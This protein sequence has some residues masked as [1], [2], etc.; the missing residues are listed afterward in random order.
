MEPDK[1]QE[2]QFEYPYHYIPDW[3]QDRFSQTHHFAWGF[4]Y[5][6][7]M[8]IVFDQLKRRSF[9]SLIDVG[10]GDGRFLREMAVC[11][12]GVALLGVDRSERAIRLA[13]A[14]NPALEYCVWDVSREAL[15]R[16]FE[17]AVLME[18]LEHVPPERIERFLES[19]TAALAEEGTLILTVPHSNLPVSGKHYQ[20]FA[21]AQLREL[22]A[23][24]FR[25]LEFIPFDPK[26]KLIGLL[27]R[28]LGGG[29][30]HFVVT[31]ATLLK[32]F[33]RLYVRKYLYARDESACTR[34]AVVAERM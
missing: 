4:R 13:Q 15:P 24:R 5:L 23:H 8:R 28:L 3:R 30:Q 17:I 1:I 2:D 31:D 20:H 18:V 27:H 22:L 34:I 33:F 25:D 26:S 19:V 6:G 12:P 11:Y 32:L 29:G 10:C 21:S 14:M 16:R 9:T 7:G